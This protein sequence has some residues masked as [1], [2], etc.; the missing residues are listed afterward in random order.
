M[1]ESIP[2]HA[3]ISKRQCT[4]SVVEEFYSYNLWIIPLRLYWL[5]IFTRHGTTL[6][7]TRATRDVDYFVTTECLPN[8][9]I[10]ET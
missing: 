2:N 7:E 6:S 9:V 4:G 8:S 10:T 3:V 1:S 5:R